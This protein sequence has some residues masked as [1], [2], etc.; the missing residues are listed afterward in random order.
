MPLA[1]STTRVIPFAVCA[2]ALV[3]PLVGRSAPAAQPPAAKPPAVDVEVR[4]VDDS[5]MKLKVL[6]ERLELQTRYGTLQIPVADV[7]RIEFATRTP[8]E[9]AERVTV[10][11]THLNH[12]DYDSRE[13]ANAELRGYRERAY[14]PLV[15]AIKHADAEI[16]RRAEE[17]VRDLQNK[18][19]GGTLEPREDDV[20][21]TADS[22][23][24]GRLTAPAL[25][26]Q[27]AMFGEQTLR[28]ADARTLR[29]AAG[30]VADETANAPAGPTNLMAFQ[31]QIGKEAVFSV[32]APQPGGQ[33]I[34]VWGTDVYTLD[35]NLGAA[36]VHAGVVQPGQAG[37]VRVRVVTPPA[38]FAGTARNGI[39]STPYGTY[40]AG[41]FEFVRK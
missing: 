37:V 22:R 16:S 36:A 26:V 27:T 41:G 24:A 12:P 11:I 1:R 23:I 32:T 13:R 39:G 9:V 38:Q 6:D 30:A 20:I 28:L 34:G 40:P 21:H 18:L 17:T 19:P 3:V 5:T 8:P 33:N 10:L 4:C 31:N 35:S 25:R 15:K 2:L 29:S 14:F 7:R